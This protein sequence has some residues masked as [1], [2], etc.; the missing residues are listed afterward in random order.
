MLPPT[1][2]LN[3]P[4]RYRSFIV[5]LS[6]VFLAL[7]SILDMSAQ[8]S[9]T[10][11]VDQEAVRLSPFEVSSERVSGY[12]VTDSAASRI[13]RELINVPTS[14]QVITSE[15]IEDIGA[16]S[17][18]DAAQYLSG[19]SV[20][21]NGGITGTQERQTV[22]GF[23]VVGVTV[24]NF[25]PG[26]NDQSFDTEVIDRVEV[27]KGPNAILAPSG[28]PGGVGNVLT[29]S[30]KFISPSHTIKTEFADQYFG[31]K[32]TLDSTGRVLNSKSLA[33]RL[34]ATYRD[35]KSYVPGHINSKSINPMFTWMVSETMQLKFKGF[36]TN[37][38]QSGP[39]T[40][41]TLYLADNFPIGALLSSD[42]SNFRPGYELFGSNAAPD[43]AKREEKTRRATV[44][45]TTALS[46]HMNLRLAANRHY[47]HFTGLGGGV[48]FDRGDL[49]NRI[50]PMTG[51][52]TETQ[53]WDLL[54]NT[55][56]WDA[57][58]NPYVPT[59]I[60][61]AS[62][63]QKVWLSE[64]HARYWV[65]ETHLQGD[66]AGEFDFGGTE[67]EPLITLNIVTGASRAKGKNRYLGGAGY[68]PEEITGSY[69]KSQYLMPN[70]G[71]PSIAN[72]ISTGSPGPIGWS[73]SGELI[74]NIDT[75]YYA[76]AQVDTFR[77]RLILNAGISHQKRENKY[78][79]HVDGSIDEWKSSMSKPSYA[80]L[81]K[82]HSNASVYV[83]HS[84]NSDRGSWFAGP[85]LGDQVILQDGKQNEVGLKFDFF[86][87]RLSV[88][89]SYFEIKKENIPQA[90]PRNIGLPDRIYPDFLSDITNEGLELDIS[91]QITSNL[92]FLGSF[93]NQ[94][95]RDQLGRKQANVPDTM[96]NA[97]IRYKFSQGSLR[98]L[99]MHLGFN[100]VEKTSGENP[101]SAPTPLGVIP[102]PGFYLP[103][104]TIFNAGLS[105]TFRVLKVQLNIDNLTDEKKPEKSF[106][107]NA[108]GLTPPRNVRL[109]TSYSF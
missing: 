89:T 11:L 79:N 104:R 32:A 26:A 45:F 49:G 80:A 13:R 95:M 30:P 82:L 53:R 51:E 20:P 54:D 37:W 68:Y 42:K 40:P 65:E 27:I 47:A 105:Y 59:D 7:A 12:R 84:V 28:P 24:D 43:W 15:F 41:S 18:L 108:I 14:I 85:S 106:G 72:W 19:V 60:D 78:L 100:H 16:T 103:A 33:Y 88:T 107:R 8:G 91:G 101:D 35:A 21:P 9:V 92:S 63:I 1:P 96:V 22:R 99:G 74:H 6:L 29:K 34:I 98:G 86:D 44:E 81:F 31:N 10:P 67:N 93:T 50:N 58:T 61:W 75:Q 46:S 76:N 109:T 2:K 39:A 102:Q 73:A 64:N 36:F 4:E 69:D 55:L 71:R 56:A 97:L 52:W 57:N 90:D 70:P 38:W 5:Y 66:L 94:K 87:R 62:S 48:T 17:I 23:E 25:T 77:G 3:T 83:A